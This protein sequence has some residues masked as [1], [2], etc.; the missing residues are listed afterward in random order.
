MGAQFVL[1]GR[2]LAGSRLLS[3]VLKHWQ[4]ANGGSQG[5][6]EGAVQRP[7]K[8]AF[9]G[10]PNTMAVP[11]PATAGCARNANIGLG[12]GSLLSTPLVP[13]RARSS[14]VSPKLREHRRAHGHGR[15]S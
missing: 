1:H 7:G 5:S 9:A 6:S 10:D 8:L 11:V 3:E 14:L 2:C 15:I 12:A 13:S 4:V